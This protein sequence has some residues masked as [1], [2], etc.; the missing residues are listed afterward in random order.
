MT[1]AKLTSSGKA[2]LVIDDSG[3]VFIAPLS[4][5]ESLLCS[6]VPLVSFNRL[7]Y[8]L[9]SGRFG[10]SDLWDSDGTKKKYSEL[11]DGQVPIDSSVQRKKEEYK[12]FDD[13][14]VDV[15]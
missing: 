5:F 3:N 13:V 7:P 10:Q 9:P 11:E 6:R 12:I 14:I 2:V 8:A 1:V 15:K 4:T